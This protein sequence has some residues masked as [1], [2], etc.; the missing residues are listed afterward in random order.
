[1]AAMSLSARHSSFPM[2]TTF[3]PPAPPSGSPPRKTL[4]VVDDEDGP[5]QSLRV[6]FKDDYNV[7]LANDGP[8][9]LQLARNQRIDA[10]VVD[11]RMVGMLSL[12]HISEPTRL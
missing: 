11:I 9:A 7:L 12:I 2:D 10:A 3:K 6:V 8:S 5:R 4:L 1:M